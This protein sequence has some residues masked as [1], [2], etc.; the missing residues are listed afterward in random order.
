LRNLSSLDKAV[1]IHVIARNQL[2]KS[3]Y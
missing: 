2:K 1:F 3:I